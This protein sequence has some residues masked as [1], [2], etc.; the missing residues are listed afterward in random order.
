MGFLSNFFNRGFRFF[1]RTQDGVTNFNLD[2]SG[3]AKIMFALHN[4]A[5]LK[6]CALQCEMFS[7]GKFYVY[8][9]GKE[10]KE[11]PFLDFLE[12]PN[13]LQSKQQFLWDYMFWQMIGVSYVMHE[14]DIYDRSK[15][16]VI[17]L[18]KPF[19]IEYPIDF[20][21]KLN[22][23]IFSEK[24][25][26][27]I[28]DTDIMYW[29][30]QG[31]YKLVKYGRLDVI[32]DLGSPMSKTC[33]EG[34]ID[35]LI[36]PL[37]NNEAAMD[38]L[39]INTRYSG[40]YI[41]TSTQNSDSSL[42]LTHEEQESIETKLDRSRRLHAVRAPIDIKRFVENAGNQK[43]PEAWLHTY[44]QIGTMYGIPRDVMEAYESGTYENQ[45]KARGAHVSY[46]LQP[47]GDALASKLTAR[48]LRGS[49]DKLVMS[50][51]DQ[52]FMQ[53]LEKDRADTLHK[54]AE[55]VRILQECGV[56][57]E[58][59]NAH[60]DLTLSYGRPQRTTQEN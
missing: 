8:R 46:T 5:F 32:S 34:R 2:L 37:F 28:L 22:Q 25:Y 15:K 38:A 13:Y 18:L 19:K 43:L 27:E 17:Q 54:K 42:P 7:I 26:R 30:D 58:S 24:T 52:P 16:P 45:E 23:P 49:K 41:V 31:D 21:Y 14:S 39:N 53:F 11:H 20:E 51:D 60:V 57:D 44:F 6:I 29:G 40:K 59:I 50:W 12:N 10:V 4:P 33:F 1:G 36:K 55:T 3:E 56:T 9:D 48:Y 47:K 35:A